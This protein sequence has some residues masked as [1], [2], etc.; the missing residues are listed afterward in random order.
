M[1]IAMLI[2]IF[3]LVVCSVV[4]IIRTFKKSDIYE[5]RLCQLQKEENFSSPTRIPGVSGIIP[6][7]IK[8]IAKIFAARSYTE[9]IQVHLI[10]AG[11]M[12]KGEEYITIC[13]LLLIGAPL[14]T[15]LL[16]SNIW[17]SLAMLIIGIFIPRAY[18]N[19]RKEKRTALLDQ[20]LGDGLVVMANALRA[21]FG[22]Q[23]A[24]DMVRKELPPPISAEFTWAL[25]EMNLGFSQ[26]EALLNMGK[27]VNS[28]DLDMVI[29]GIL[30]QR[31]V[32]GNLAEILDKISN[33][34]R[35]RAQLKKGIRILTAQGRLSGIIIGLLPVALILAML[36]IN[37]DYINIL[38]QDTRGIF[39]LALAVVMMLI[40]TI[41]IKKIITI[42]L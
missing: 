34:I 21:G 32:G 38:F 12:L 28:E 10:R 1:E 3:G 7:L 22:F 33:T 6:N 30:I 36:A 26:E 27:R 11:I 13:L 39:I 41:V 17:L 14:L 2:S 25:R 18:L 35:E 19:H 4:A 31:Q 40:G 5:Q 9:E 8:Y 16:T 24:M 42:D 23:Q 29:T 20:Q 37:P 15:W